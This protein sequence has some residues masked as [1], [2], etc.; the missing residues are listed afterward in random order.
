MKTLGFENL[1]SVSPTL[2]EQMKK[3][4]P[5]LENRKKIQTLQSEEESFNKTLDRGMELFS[6]QIQLQPE[7]E[8][9]GSFAF[10]LYDT[11]GFP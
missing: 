5:E 2:I 9:S 1:F 10:K 4:F 3:V 7:Q 8:I 6:R 11:Y